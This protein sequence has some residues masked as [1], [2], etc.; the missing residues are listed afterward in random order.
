MSAGPAIAHHQGDERREAG[1]RA[2]RDPD[3]E[4]EGVGVVAA[5]LERS[6]V[7]WGR[8]LVGDG[9]E[10]DQRRAGDHQHVEDVPGGRGALGGADD[11]S[12]PAFRRRL[13]ADH[14]QEHRGREAAAA[15]ERELR[16]RPSRPGAAAP[17]LL[18]TTARPANASG[19][20]VRLRSGA[21]TIPECHGG[22]SA[23]DPDAR[24]RARTT[25][26]RSTPR[27]AERRRARTAGCPPGSPGRRSSPRTRGPRRPGS[28]RASRCRR[29]GRPGSGPRSARAAAAKAAASAGWIVAA[30][31]SVRA[32]RLAAGLTL[33]DRP[34]E[35][36]LDRPEKDRDRAR[37]PRTKGRPP[38]R[39]ACWLEVVRGE[40][41]VDVG[42][43]A[44]RPD[45]DREHPAERPNR[46]VSAG[47]LARH[48]V[49][50]VTRS[51]VGPQSVD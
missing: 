31:R 23:G 34:R 6:R 24:P 3:R 45:P 50:D 18:A 11:Q 2:Q 40:R 26:G 17:S 39:T 15:R 30:T 47:C 12:G 44:R 43:H 46:L 20:T 5:S 36:L 1:D 38:R 28:S 19:T 35:E 7:R 32:D 48:R 22:L 9:L 33:G 8:R 41:E 21:A 51:A 13:L 29:A 27:A 25:S 49:G 16:S 4:P 14:D 42:E 10:E 37:R